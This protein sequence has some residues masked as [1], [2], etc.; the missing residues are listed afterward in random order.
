MYDVFKQF[1]RFTDFFELKLACAKFVG[2]AKG[3]RL[4][5]GLEASMVVVKHTNIKMVVLHKFFPMHCS[6]PMNSQ[7][8]FIFLSM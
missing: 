6:P 3:S 5:E 2:I 7:S 8:N 4:Y 1:N